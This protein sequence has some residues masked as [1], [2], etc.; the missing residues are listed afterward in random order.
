MALRGRYY[1]ARG[2]LNRVLSMT[3]RVTVLKCGAHK[4]TIGPGG[5]HYP[6]AFIDSI[7][8]CT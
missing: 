5:E 7:P 3:C 1:R 8:H 6:I 2:F 4:C